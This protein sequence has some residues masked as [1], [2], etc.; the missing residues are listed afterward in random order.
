MFPHSPFAQSSVSVS[1]YS[2]RFESPGHYKLDQN[3]ISTHSNSQAEQAD[4]AEATSSSRA[5]Q[6]DVSGLVDQ[7]WSFAS[8]RIEQARQDGASDEELE[9]L[10]TAAEKGVSQGFQEAKDM[11]DDMGELDEPLAMK[12]DSAYGQLMDKLDKRNLNDEQAPVPSDTTDNTPSTDNSSSPV[13]RAIDLYQYQRQTFSLDLQTAQGDTIQIR[14]V[15]ESTANASDFRFG[16]LSSTQWSSGENN[17]YSLV[18]NG[19]L[20][21]QET[22]DLDAL[23]AEVNDLAEEFYNGDLD[24]AYEMASELDI[25]GSSLM[26]LDLSMNEAESKGASVYAET[27][28]APSVLPK[29]L[30]PLRD[31]ADKLIAAQD[32]WHQH[33]NSNSDLLNSIVNHPRDNGPLA[34]FAHQLLF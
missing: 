16:N 21:E 10:W 26:S 2:S 14:A 5:D 13:D 7:I 18:I 33:F 1:G 27:A 12:I 15:N 34:Q 3:P 6:F 25:T 30:T 23:L 32:K 20:N 24:K 22:A 11:L 29:G 31:Y 9:S 4:E 8:H 19:D 17:A 28:G